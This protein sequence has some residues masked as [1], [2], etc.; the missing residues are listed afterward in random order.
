[1]GYALKLIDPVTKE[2]LHSA[3]PHHICGS[4]FVAGGTT[5]CWFSITYNYSEHLFRALGHK[6][7]RCIYGLT[8]AESI[9][10]LRAGVD[11]LKDDDGS[12]NY[13]NP[14]EANTKRAL[15]SLIEMAELR[16]DGV[17]AGD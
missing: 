9:E 14:T 10:I 2:T 17:W 5:E 4:T 6:G 7:I 12:Q 3:K 11:K 8:G 1:M 15:L 13:W 16:P